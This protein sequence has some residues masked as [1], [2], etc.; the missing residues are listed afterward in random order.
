[1]P[2]VSITRA[3]S[4]LAVCSLLSGSALA[5]KAPSAE[6]KAVIAPL[7][8][9]LDGLAKRD[10]ALM[11][12]QLFPGGS[13]TLMRDGKPVQMAFDAFVERLAQPGT[14]TR[15]ERIYEPLVRIDDNIAIVW[16]RFDFVLNGK[17][18]HCGTDVVNLVKVDR[19]WLIVFLGD[20][21]R[22]GCAAQAHK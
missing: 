17:V 12:A 1:M 3:F 4:F 7:Q 6:E 20:T 9:L 11:A 13:A 21:S 10:K 22:T 16:T 8:A 5:A 18:D 2:F 19:K 14:D 15:Q